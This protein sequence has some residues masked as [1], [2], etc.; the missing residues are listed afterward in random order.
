MTS[1]NC[2]QT[3]NRDVAVEREALQA[4]I[5]MLSPV[6]PHFCH[7]LWNAMGNTG[8]VIDAQWP[9]V[10]EQAMVR[11]TIELVVSGQW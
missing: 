1:P 9:V 2:R 6:A 7:E 8:A 4:I 11:N 10:D 5:V 3:M